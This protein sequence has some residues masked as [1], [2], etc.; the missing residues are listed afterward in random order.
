MNRTKN[1]LT[2]VLAISTAVFSAAAT[3]PTDIA[4]S[5][6]TEEIAV[7]ECYMPETDDPT[8]QFPLVVVDSHEAYR[9]WCAISDKSDN[10]F[11]VVAP[12]PDS[13]ISD[14]VK[15]ISGMTDNFEVD[16][17]R[18]YLVISDANSPLA[19]APSVPD[20]FATQ[21]TVDYTTS[22]SPE[23]VADLLSYIRQ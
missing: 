10:P 14:F 20:I 15:Y 12:L 18:V 23:T 6:S 1:I 21:I 13:P 9:T 16:A 7:A 3:M 22:I 4:E 17:D 2:A 8:V 19:Q 5:S 11:A